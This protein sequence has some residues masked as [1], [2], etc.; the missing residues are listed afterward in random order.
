MADYKV[1]LRYATSLIDLALEKNILDSVS[2]DIEFVGDTLEKCPELKRALENPV[3]KPETKSSILDEIFKSRINPE[4]MHFIRFLVKKGRENLLGEIVSKFLGL[5]DKNMN[6]VNVD[7]QSA[8]EM[9]E[10]QKEKLK[11]RI[12]KV[13]NKKARFRIKINPEVVG[14]FIAKVNDTVYDASVKHQLETLKQIL[15]KNGTALN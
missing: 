8:Y 6:I 2:N 5:R 14:G 11:T 13:L 9:T 3:I 10:D 15:L 12:E 1:S 4:T 7:V